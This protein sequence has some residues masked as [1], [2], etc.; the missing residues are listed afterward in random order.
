MVELT[1]DNISRDVTWFITRL[2]RNNLTDPNSRSTEWIFKSQST[3][4]ID[5]DLPRVV[6]DVSEFVTEQTMLKGKGTY[7]VPKDIVVEIMIYAD[8]IRNRDE[9][10]DD[11]RDVLFNP[12]SADDEGDSLKS[13][14]LILRR[15]I[16]GVEDFYAEHPKIIRA[17]RM[18]C[19][20]RYSG[21]S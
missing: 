1:L 6:V 7:F 13:N 11:I 10:T 20:F 14:H 19:E 2:L 3:E 4:P 16:E 5:Y 8:S 17:K 15:C 12:D 21:V 9:I 18:V